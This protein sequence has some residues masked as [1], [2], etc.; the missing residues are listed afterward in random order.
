MNGQT[1]NTTHELSIQ[2][3][4]FNP[5]KVIET[6]NFVAKLKMRLSKMNTGH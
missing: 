2:K 1:A 4:V 6:N 5:K 3:S